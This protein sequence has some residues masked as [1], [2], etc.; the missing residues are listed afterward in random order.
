MN[1]AIGSA[2]YY[3]SYQQHNTIDC[4]NHTSYH[5]TGYDNG[6]NNAAYSSMTNNIGCLQNVTAPP[7]DVRVDTSLLDKYAYGYDQYYGTTSELEHAPVDVTG[8]S[9]I[10]I[11]H[12]VFTDIEN[13]NGCY[14]TESSTDYYDVSAAAHDPYQHTAPAPQLSATN[15]YLAHNHVAYTTAAATI[16]SMTSRPNSRGC[17]T[18]RERNRMH[19]LND[20]FEELRKVVPR[21]NV[22]EHQRLSKI[23]TLRLAIQYIGALAGALTTAGVEIKLN[24]DD[25]IYDRRGRRN[26]RLRRNCGIYRA[27]QNSSKDN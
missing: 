5:A 2:S 16:T 26:G 11:P 12:Q 24:V 23:A 3:G 20:G 27:A 7:E 25:A 10:Q 4:D 14:M 8:M 18:E 21:S 19:L 1:D 22:G 6:D 15:V 13:N 9:K 17:A